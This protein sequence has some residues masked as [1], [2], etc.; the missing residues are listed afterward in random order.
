LLFSDAE[1]ELMKRV[2]D[3]FNAESLLNP[4][5]I[6]PTGKTCGEIRVRPLPISGGSPA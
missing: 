4:G 2:R 3:A 6:I 1:L 5:K